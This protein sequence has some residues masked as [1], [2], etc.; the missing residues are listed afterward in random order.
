MTLYYR[1]E[2]LFHYIDIT[3]SIMEEQSPITRRLYVT[4][5]LNELNQIVLKLSQVN[6]QMDSSLSFED[7]LLD[8]SSFDVIFERR[9]IGHWRFDFYGRNLT[10]L[11]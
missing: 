2:Y 1:L 6:N 3:D 8:I 5:I 4:G 7:A 11:F 9:M 10:F